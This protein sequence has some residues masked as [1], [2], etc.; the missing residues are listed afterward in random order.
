[1]EA[2]GA[3]LDVV[4]CHVHVFAPEICADRDPHLEADPWFG[5]LYAN[6]RAA[7]I[8]AETLI[9]AM[10]AAGVRRAVMCGFPW[11][12]AGRCREHNDYMADAAHRFPERLSW[13]GI[14]APAVPDAAG[15]AVRCFQIGAT[16]IGE[17][18]ADA[19]GFD[20]RETDGL[21]DLV[22]TCVAAERPVLLHA[23]EAVGHGYP[24]KGTATPGKLLIF[25]QAFPLLHVVAAHWGGGL[26][27]HELMPEV[28]AVARNVVYD[29]AASTYLYRPRV[30]RSVLDIVGRDRVLFGSDYPVLRMDRFLKRVLELDWHDDEERAAV[31]A[32]NARRVFRLPGDAATS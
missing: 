3:G 13:L 27:F 5:T 26:P 17:L 1:M 11:A 20:W 15:E 7:L 4:D 6:P 21:R 14:V 8:T 24:G 31:L 2:V 32:G 23:S 9:D 12:D 28:E 29:C 30:F 16:G 19:Q 18:N 10:D 25:L 22:E